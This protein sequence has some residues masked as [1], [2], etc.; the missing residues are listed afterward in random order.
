MPKKLYSSDSGST[1]AQ[2]LDYSYNVRG[3][4]T[5]INNPKSLGTDLFGLELCYNK[6]TDITSLSD[7]TPYYNG[8]ISGTLWAGKD[9]TNAVRAGAYAFKYDDLNRLKSADYG[10]L[11]GST[12]TDQTSKFNVTGITYDK[13]GN[14]LTLNRDGE[15]ASGIDKLAY[16]YYSNTN[17]LLYVN[18]TGNDAVGFKELGGDNS[19]EYYYDA[20]GNMLQD[21]NKL[22]SSNITYNHLNLPTALTQNSTNISYLYDGEGN[23]LRHTMGTNTTDYDGQFIYENNA[24]SQILFGEGRLVVS[25]T[26]AAY[27]FFL[28]DHLGN[29]RVTFNESA[30]PIQTIA[31]YPFGMEMKFY[32]NTD[33]QFR[34][35][36]K[37]LQEG[38][39]WYDYG[40]RFY[41]PELARWHSVDPLAE[42]YYS[43]SSYVYC[44]ANPISLFDPDGMRIEWGENVSKE[45]KKAIRK[46]INQWK[47]SSDSFKADYK[48]I[49][50]SDYVYTI[51]TSSSGR[52]ANFDGNEKATISRTDEET[53]QVTSFEMGDTPGGTITFNTKVLGDDPDSG[54][55]QDLLKLP[56][57]EEIAH[58]AQYDFWVN[59]LSSNNSALLPG[60]A[61]R[62][63]EAKT[64]V[65][66]Y[67]AQAGMSDQ[68]KTMGDFIPHNYGAKLY[69]G[70]GS[71]NSYSSRFSA[72]WANSWVQKQY[73]D[74]NLTHHNPLFLKNKLKK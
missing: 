41:D 19:Q 33:N 57:A 58:T 22:I 64:V 20:N 71:L 45:D 67:M 18:D 30:T 34:Y 14:I 48:S 31:Y 23:K 63:M 10:N 59:E 55:L 15:T 47:K 50:K 16:H 32:G 3:W 62:E 8:N 17:K 39:D 1:F 54:E 61:D 66:I 68:N 69:T 52:I 13:N 56:L 5:A 26:S 21:R 49:K 65:G 29:T 4:L 44:A 40:A 72:W 42:K 53:G 12:I 37:E 60:Y 73:G 27:E 36:G 9:A 7:K 51:K 6:T 70:Q 11:S 2:Q 74:M 43:L 38:T 46:V 25:G 35:N 24:L 28:K